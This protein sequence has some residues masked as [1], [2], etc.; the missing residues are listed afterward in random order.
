M[1]SMTTESCSNGVNIKRKSRF[2]QFF[3]YKCIL[4]RVISV[5]TR[6]WEVEMVSLDIA[7]VN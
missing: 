5:C 3:W 6:V 7:G 2:F 4:K 1:S